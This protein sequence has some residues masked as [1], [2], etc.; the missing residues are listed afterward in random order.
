MNPLSAGLASVSIAAVVTML[1][2]LALMNH[3]PS[4][5]LLKRLPIVF[6]SAWLLS[7]A[8]LIIFGS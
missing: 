6:F 2:A 8:S 7:A 3:V 4:E 1:A 5:R